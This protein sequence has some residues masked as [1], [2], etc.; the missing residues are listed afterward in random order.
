[1]ARRLVLDEDYEYLS[2]IMMYLRDG[3]TQIRE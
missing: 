2:D 1:M 3:F